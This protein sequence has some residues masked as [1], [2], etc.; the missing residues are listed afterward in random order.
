MTEVESLEHMLAN[1]KKGLPAGR[2]IL[3]RYMCPITDEHLSAI[4]LRGWR[5]LSI[6][7]D[8][9]LEGPVAAALEKEELTKGK[10]H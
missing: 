10:R 1:V 8:H 3:N 2:G 4:D 6:Q 5:E 9:S 7:T